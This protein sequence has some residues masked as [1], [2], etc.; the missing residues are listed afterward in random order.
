M[1]QGCIKVFGDNDALTGRQAVIF[2]DVGAPKVA[3]AV[4]ASSR[5]VATLAIAVGT[6]ALAITSLAKA[7][8]PSSRAAGLDGPKTAKPA[9]RRVSETP[10]TRGFGANDDQV[11]GQFGG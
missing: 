9:S 6:L 7:L 5:L 10:A 4:S 8:D 11:S 2:N 1:G 3:R